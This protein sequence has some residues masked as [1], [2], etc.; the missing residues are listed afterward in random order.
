[1][2]V[3]RATAMR[4]CLQYEEPYELGH[5]RVFVG[6]DGRGKYRW[7][8]GRVALPSLVV[9]CR[10]QQQRRRRRQANWTSSASAS[11]SINMQPCT[12]LPPKSRTAPAAT[13]PLLSSAALDTSNYF[14]FVSLGQENRMQ[15]KPVPKNTRVWDYDCVPVKH[16]GT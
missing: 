2:P 13:A 12:A 16:D 10:Q 4:F 11:D 6:R 14:T 15:H 5:L 7:A 8:T 9:C 1:V 3:S